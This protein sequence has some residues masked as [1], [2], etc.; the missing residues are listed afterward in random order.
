[1]T[2]SCQKFKALEEQIRFR[3][4]LFLLYI[5]KYIHQ[6]KDFHLNYVRNSTTKLTPYKISQKKPLIY[7]ILK[8]TISNWSA[9]NILIFNRMHL[10]YLARK[11]RN[12]RKIQNTLAPFQNT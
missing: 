12:E 8:E 7:A 5:N 2:V 4:H 9:A 6:L 10:S 1:M 11:I 3:S